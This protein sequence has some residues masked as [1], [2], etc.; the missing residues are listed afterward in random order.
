MALNTL[1]NKTVDCTCNFHSSQSYSDYSNRSLSYSTMIHSLLSYCV[2]SF[3]FQ[4]YN[5]FNSHISSTAIVQTALLLKDTNYTAPSL[6]LFSIF[7]M[8]MT[9]R[10][11]L[12]PAT[13]VALIMWSTYAILPTRF[14]SQKSYGSLAESSNDFKCTFFTAWHF[15]TRGQYSWDLR[16]E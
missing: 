8:S 10:G 3:S 14:K 5:D 16:V 7:S 11:L 4:W 1:N 6:W 2:D 13:L 12:S 15:K 9:H